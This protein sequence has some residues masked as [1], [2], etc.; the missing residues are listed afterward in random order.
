MPTLKINKL[1]HCPGDG[2]ILQLNGFKG[3]LSVYNAIRCSTTLKDAKFSA[4]QFVKL[5]F[6]NM[7]ASTHLEDMERKPDVVI[8]KFKENCNLY[9]NKWGWEINFLEL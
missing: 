7:L 2:S 3:K 6:A 4:E 5:S 9:L 1:P 8:N